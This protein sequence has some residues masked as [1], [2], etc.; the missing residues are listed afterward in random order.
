MASTTTS[1]EQDQNSNRTT[2]PLW[3]LSRLFFWK[4]DD[5][6]LKKA[7]NLY[8]NT[9]IPGVMLVAITILAV[10]SIFWGS[11]WKN[12]DHTLPGWIVDFDGGQV[13]DFVAKTLLTER[14]AILW[15]VVPALTAFPRGLGELTQAVKE[16]RTWVAVVVNADATLRLQDS[17]T[18]PNVSYDGTEAISIYAVEARNENSYRYVIKPSV[19]ASMH[20]VQLAFAVEFGANMSSISNINSII[21]MS[22]QTIVNPLSFKFINLIP[23]SQP[24]A[25]A[26]LS[27]GLIFVL[28]MSYF[29]VT[30]ANGARLASGLPKL[31]SFRHLIALR[32]GTLFIVYFFLSLVYSLVNLAFKLDLGHKYGHGG[33]VLFWIVSWTYMLA[34]GLALESLITVM[35]QFVPFFLITW[36]VVNVSTNSYPIEVLPKIFHYGY[37][38]PFYNVSKAIRTIVFGTRNTLG[39]NVGIL[40]IWV[41]ISCTTLVGFQWYV[42]KREID[43][44]RE[45]RHEHGVETPNGEKQQQV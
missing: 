11:A 42:R 34:V 44:V 39:K 17:I 12:P 9:V 35:K 19:E 6:E 40:I 31:L 22:P 41:I 16:D 1:V 36:I 15:E 8:L 10:F 26:T 43:A 4:G 28:I 30:I 23:F 45:A 14:G 2:L 20:A 3:P 13:G 5:E 29:V 21:A 37:A 24:V 27:T 18:S 7:W 32:L 25:V 38:T 33:F